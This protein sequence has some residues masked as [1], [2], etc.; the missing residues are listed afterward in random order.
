MKLLKGQ[1]SDLCKRIPYP[2]KQKDILS[3]ISYSC[4]TVGKMG[5]KE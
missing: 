5:E 4:I 1:Q 2:V 3:S